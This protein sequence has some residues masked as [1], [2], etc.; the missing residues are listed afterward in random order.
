MS[1]DEAMGRLR[2]LAAEADGHLTAAAV[3]DDAWCSSNQQLVCAATHELAT[4]SFVSVYEESDGRAWFPYSSMIFS[5][6]EPVEMD[7]QRL[8]EDLRPVRSSAGKHRAK[9]SGPPP[10][11]RLSRAS[12]HRPEWTTDSPRVYRYLLYD[13]DGTDQGE[14]E[15]AVTINVG[16]TIRTGDG[17]QLRVIG[18]IPQGE[19]EKYVGLLTVEPL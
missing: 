2:E 8:V 6:P 3:E 5:E 14:A 16:E 9:V 1:L 19:S 17:R 11:E 4:E 7:A 18:H 10:F 15:Y 12:T 13:L